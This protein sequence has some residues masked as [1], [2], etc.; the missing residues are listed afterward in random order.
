MGKQQHT[1]DADFDYEDPRINRTRAAVHEAGLAVLFES[2]TEGITHAALA[3][4][5]GMSRTTLYK[6]WPTRVELL[7]D[8]CKQVEPH[9]T[10]ELTGDTR[11]DLVAMTLDVADLLRDP[12]ARRAFSS[13]LA[14][15]QSDPDALKVSNVLSGDGLAEITQVLQAAVADGQIPCGID[16]EEVAGRLLGPILFGALVTRRDTK[17]ADVEAIVDAWLASVTP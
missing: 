5:T 12:H 11:T 4:A 13:L 15:A 10:T 3:T 9:N 2:G 16:A 17:V 6:H 1:A 8:I 7:I 14:Q